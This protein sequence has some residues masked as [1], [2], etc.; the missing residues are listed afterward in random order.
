MMPDPEKLL[1]HSDYSKRHPVT[2]GSGE[3]WLLFTFKEGGRAH[4]ICAGGFSP[5]IHF[6]HGSS[7]L[8]TV[9]P[10][11]CTVQL[12]SV[13][14]TNAHSAWPSLSL[15]ACCRIINREFSLLHSD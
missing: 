7:E 11:R 6:A 12:V 10:G 9:P 1:T 3:W 8:E 13:P 2:T 14:P 4:Q 15:A 5:Q